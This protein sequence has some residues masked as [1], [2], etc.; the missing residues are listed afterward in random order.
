ME[1]T[2][3]KFQIQLGALKIFLKGFFQA[4]I[5]CNFQEN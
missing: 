2:L 1:K 3:A 5:L 4:I